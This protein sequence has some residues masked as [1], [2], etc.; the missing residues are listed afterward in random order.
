MTHGHSF[1]FLIITACVVWYSTVTLFVTIKGSADIRGMLRDLRDRD[2][3]AKAN[4][5]KDSTPP[6]SNDKTT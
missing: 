5:A 4:A 1:W 2:A 3:A 6:P